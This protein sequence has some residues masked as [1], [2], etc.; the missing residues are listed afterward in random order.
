MTYFRLVPVAS[1]KAAGVSGWR[2][3]H[4]QRARSEVAVGRHRVGQVGLEHDDP[5]RPLELA[6]AGRGASGCPRG[7]G[8]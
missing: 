1:R 5:R 3:R 4:R 8:E 7:V 6:D 2:R